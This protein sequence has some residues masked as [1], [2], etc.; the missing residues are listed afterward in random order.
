MIKNHRMYFGHFIFMTLAGFAFLGYSSNSSAW[1]HDGHTA[2]GV[3]AV[4][5]LQQNTLNELESIIQPLNKQAMAE[6]CNWPDVFRE[7]EEG[8]WSA[9]PA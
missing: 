4:N 7:T 2:V 5:Q 3:L 8:E 9:P 6:A 1:G